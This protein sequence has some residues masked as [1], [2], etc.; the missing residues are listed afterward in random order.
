MY[1]WMYGSLEDSKARGM[2]LLLS[3]NSSKNK[4]NRPDSQ[5]LPFFVF[6]YVFLSVSFLFDIF[7]L[8]DSM[9]DGRSS[10]VRHCQIGPRELL[11]S[12]VH[13]NV[14]LFHTLTHTLIFYNILISCKYST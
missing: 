12:N 3:P 1:A 9:K 13:V 5:D 4:L 14:C 6:V 8:G 10:A 7:G 2:F 11:G